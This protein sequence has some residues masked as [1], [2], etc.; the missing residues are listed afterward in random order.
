[1][2][3]V[4]LVVNQKLVVWLCN[5]INAYVSGLLVNGVLPEYAQSDVVQWNTFQL[6]ACEYTLFDIFIHHRID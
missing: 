2:S 3:Q 6:D 1:V 4:T 5:S